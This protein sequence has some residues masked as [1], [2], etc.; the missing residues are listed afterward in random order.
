MKSV[1]VLCNSEVE[2]PHLLA[3][4]GDVVSLATRVSVAAFVEMHESNIL[5][6]AFHT[7]DHLLSFDA[8]AFLHIDL[9]SSDWTEI[10]E[11]HTPIS[12]F[13]CYTD[14]SPIIAAARDNIFVCDLRARPASLIAQNNITKVYLLADQVTFAAL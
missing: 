3:I 14:E 10:F 7:C 8:A 1:L 12:A 5:D 4:G 2:S 13:T 6:V 11:S 9:E